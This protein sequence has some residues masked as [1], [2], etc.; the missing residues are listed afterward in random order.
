VA[1][2]QI[3]TAAAGR[4]PDEFLPLWEAVTGHHAGLRSADPES[5]LPTW[6]TERLR[7]ATA[8]AAGGGGEHDFVV[9]AE[10]SGEL[11]GY[12]RVEIGPGGPTFWPPVDRVGRLETLSV[13]G[14]RRR[15][16]IG[17]QLVAGVVGELG[18]RRVRLV[19]VGFWRENVD[20]GRFYERCGFRVDGRGRHRRACP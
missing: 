15:Q 13:I 14:S 11:V 17:G 9:A 2:V 12:A 8:L 18:L 16:G 19:V 4:E 1:S 10:A 7:L 20:A 3:R 6:E 5:S